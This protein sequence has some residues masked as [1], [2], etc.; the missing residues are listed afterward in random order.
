MPELMRAAV[1]HRPGGPEVLKLERHAHAGI[2]S[3]RSPPGRP[4]V[5]VGRVFGLEHIVEAHR[6]WKRTARGKIVVLT[7]PGERR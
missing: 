2:W 4:P 5:T 1:M 7:R 3:I 6:T